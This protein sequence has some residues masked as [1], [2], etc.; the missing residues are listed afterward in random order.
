MGQVFSCTSGICRIGCR[1][2]RGGERGLFCPECRSVFLCYPAVFQLTER[3]LS[4]PEGN[5]LLPE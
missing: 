3:P 2:D 1:G 5:C 4:V